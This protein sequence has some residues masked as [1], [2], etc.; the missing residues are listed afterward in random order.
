[1]DEHICTKV[2]NGKEVS[3][4]MYTGFLLTICLGSDASCIVVSA[5]Y[6]LA[7]EHPYPAA[8]ED[9]YDALIRVFNKSPSMIGIHRPFVMVVGLSAFV[10]PRVYEN[11]SVTNEKRTFRGG[12]LAVANVIKAIQS[13]LDGGLRKLV[14][15]APT[16]DH[17]EQ[18][19]NRKAG[20][21]G[22]MH[23]C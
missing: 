17:T 10:E 15:I 19:R 8:V 21:K 13:S 12:N 18:H 11:K 22:R 5:D 14:A 6:R 7:P 4:D 20:R 2:C 23:P 16:L 1:M 9:C 3:W